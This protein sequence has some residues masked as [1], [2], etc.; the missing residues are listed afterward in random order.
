MKFNDYVISTI[1]TT[2][3]K[4]STIDEKIIRKSMMEELDTINKYTKRANEAENQATKKLFVDI[5]HDERV[6]FEQLEELLEAIDKNYETAEDQAEE[7][8][9]DIFVDQPE[10]NDV[11]TRQ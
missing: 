11:E 1:G 7:E 5:V 2:A 9:D 8:N 6:H 10:R 4:V 3:V